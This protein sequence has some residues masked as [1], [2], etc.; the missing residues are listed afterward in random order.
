MQHHR[1]VTGAAKPL[2]RWTWRDEPKGA[3]FPSSCASNT[4][5]CVDGRWCGVGVMVT[6]RVTAYLV[7]PGL[8]LT[9]LSRPLLLAFLLFLGKLPLA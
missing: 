5:V 1:E 2:W 3:L 6:V 4:R 7:A 9:R 8:L